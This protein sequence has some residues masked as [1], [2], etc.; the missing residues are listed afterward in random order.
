MDILQW[1]VF[2]PVNFDLR[3][4]WSDLDCQEMLWNSTI[5]KHFRMGSVREAAT[6]YDDI[7]FAEA[8]GD[9][10]AIPKFEDHKVWNP[11]K[12]SVETLWLDPQLEWLF[13]IRIQPAN[14]STDTMHQSPWIS[15]FVAVSLRGEH[16]KTFVL[17]RA[18]K[19]LNFPSVFVVDTFLVPSFQCLFSSWHFSAAKP[20]SNHWFHSWQARG[21]TIAKQI[22]DHLSRPVL[23]ACQLTICWC[24]SA[25]F[26]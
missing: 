15:F 9:V 8:H 21:E 16:I 6:H 3:D 20:P 24:I 18:G 5:Y 13:D 11:Y 10:V 14:L 7:L 12:T 22:G 25:K 23:L 26:I 4:D 1:H 2:Y 17:L 19:Q